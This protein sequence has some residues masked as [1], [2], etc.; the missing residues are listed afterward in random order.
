MSDAISRSLLSL[1]VGGHFKS[2]II[3]FLIGKYIAGEFWDREG[4]NGTTKPYTVINLIDYSMLINLPSAPGEI[5]GLMVCP[6]PNAPIEIKLKG[7]G[8]DKKPGLP[9]GSFCSS[10][11]AE[12]A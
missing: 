8:I 12:T 5:I 7:D 10:H 9:Y 3:S 1:H 11:Q 4:G 2:S 6:T